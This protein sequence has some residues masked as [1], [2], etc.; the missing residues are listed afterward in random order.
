M[1][2]T[3]PYAAAMAAPASPDTG[4]CGSTGRPVAWSA[5]T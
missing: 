2:P 1:S 4:V 5:A 3:V